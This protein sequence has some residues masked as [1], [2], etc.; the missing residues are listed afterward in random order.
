MEWCFKN[1]FVYISL[2]LFKVD[3]KYVATT[4]KLFTVCINSIRGVKVVMSEEK[5][6][7]EG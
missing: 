7:L 4:S 2:L 1:I 6:E 5:K 3:I